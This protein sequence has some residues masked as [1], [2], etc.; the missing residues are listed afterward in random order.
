MKITKI[1]LQGFRAFDERFELDVACGRNLLMFGENGSG[2]SSI[3]IALRR[4]FEERGDDCAFQR[5]PAT[6][7]N[8]KRPLIPI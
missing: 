6:D 8:R 7:S 1:T 2:K 3:Y 4:F 5:N